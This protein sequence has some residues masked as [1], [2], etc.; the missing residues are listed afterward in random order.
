MTFIDEPNVYRCI[1]QS[2]KKEAEQ[3]QSWVFE[4]VLPAIRKTGGYIATNENDTEATIMAK[5]LLIAN[6]T[7]I[8]TQQELNHSKEVISLQSEELKKQAPKVEYYDKV[9][10][11]NSTYTFTQVAKE[12]GLRCAKQLTSFLQSLGYIFRQGKNWMPYAKYA[13]D[14][15]FT[16]RTYT[17]SRQDGTQGTNSQLVITEK[18]RQ[19]IHT[20]LTENENETTKT[21]QQWS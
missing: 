18:G 3:F 17:F 15:L 4:E 2:R 21:V 11:S 5:A 6:D 13:G 16:V 1:F 14:K 7:I 8:R 9:L 19:R 12:F 20:L 10:Q